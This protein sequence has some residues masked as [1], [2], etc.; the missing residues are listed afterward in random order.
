MDVIRYGKRNIIIKHAS[1]ENEILT[2]DLG[3]KKIP[4]KALSHLMLRL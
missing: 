1:Q 3:C 2:N 4:F